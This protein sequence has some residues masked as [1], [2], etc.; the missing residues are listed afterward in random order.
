MSRSGSGF[1]V[2][3]ANA[4]DATAITDLNLRLALESEGLA[5]DR[6][7]VHEGVLAVLRDTTRG[8][9]LIA[10]ASAGLAGQLMITREWSDWRNAFFWWLQSVYIEPAFRRQGALRALYSH[11]LRLARE[12]GTVC[13]L[14]LYAHDAN[15]SAQQAYRR[16]GMA[17]LPYDLLGV[18]F[19]AAGRVAPAAHP[20]GAVTLDVATAAALLDSLKDP[21]LLADT[22]HAIRYMNA[23]AIAHYK[24]GT[25]LIGRSLLDCHNPH[26]CDVIREVLDA[27]RAGESERLLS[28]GER[29]RI[30]MRAVRDPRGQLVG[31]YERYESASR[32]AGDPR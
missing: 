6:E 22:G 10:D 28:D 9:Y 30:Y 27:L 32:G 25:A 31:Y 26:S 18:D 13:G 15:A 16:L 3:T 12:E 11:T 20:A 17:P 4:E 1:Q 21:V 19:P 8:F 2:R 7:V 5:L 23:A 24:E 14:R 29:Q